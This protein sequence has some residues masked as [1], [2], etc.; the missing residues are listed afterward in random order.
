MRTELAGV[1]AR[2]VVLV[3]IVFKD[4]QVGNRADEPDLTHFLLEAQEKHDPVI[5]ADVHF[6]A[7]I[8][9]QVALLRGTQPAHIAFAVCR[10][11][12]IE[13]VQN[14]TLLFLDQK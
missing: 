6:A 1:F 7:E 14:R 2:N 4:D 13:T 8:A 11:A 9:T 3:G 10:D 5:T 12:V